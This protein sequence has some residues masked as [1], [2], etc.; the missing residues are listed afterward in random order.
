MEADHRQ[1]VD[2]STVMT[3]VWDGTGL[4]QM[5]FPGR[6]WVVNT[7]REDKGGKR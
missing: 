3:E 6:K 5:F 4:S 1:A 2:R 7:H